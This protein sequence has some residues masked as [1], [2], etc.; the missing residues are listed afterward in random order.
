LLLILTAHIPSTLYHNTVIRVSR[1]KLH[2]PQ[3]SWFMKLWG[4][5][6]RSGVTRVQN[7]GNWSI[8]IPPR[9]FSGIRDI[10]FAAFEQPARPFTT[11]NQTIVTPPYWSVTAS[12]PS[13]DLLQRY[14]DET[15][16]YEIAAGWPFVALHGAIIGQPPAKPTRRW[17]IELPIP[18]AYNDP[19]SLITNGRI[20]PLRPI[21]PGFI[22]NL[23]FWT[24]LC[25]GIRAAINNFRSRR[26]QARGHCPNPACGYPLHTLPTCPECGTPAQ[27]LPNPQSLIPDP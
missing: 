15:I 24:L 23:L 7:R 17:A 25:T 26:N 13:Q 5:P 14:G 22:L 2:D 11:L 1:P 12:P 27:H 9:R 10:H 18:S 19:G 4:G 6:A 3:P 8:S 20:L 21:F 16:G